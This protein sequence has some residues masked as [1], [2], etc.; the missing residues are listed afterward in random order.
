MKTDALSKV[1]RR[2][3]LDAVRVARGGVR[4]RLPR[5]DTLVQVASMIGLTARTVNP[6]ADPQGQSFLATV[7]LAIGRQSNNSAQDG[8]LLVSLTHP[9]ELQCR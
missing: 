7:T 6:P 5:R 8:V 3:R 2:C 9:A 4:D 1:A